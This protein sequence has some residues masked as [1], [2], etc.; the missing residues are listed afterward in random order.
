MRSSPG[1]SLPSFTHFTMRTFCASSAIVGKPPLRFVNHLKRGC[2]LI[3]TRSGGSAWRTPLDNVE[4][5]R[6]NLYLFNASR[7]S[8]WVRGGLLAT[9]S[10]G[11]NGFEGFE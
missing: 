5:H 8:N 10:A 6:Q 3:A 11:F 2:G 7:H 9:R 1:S 4:K